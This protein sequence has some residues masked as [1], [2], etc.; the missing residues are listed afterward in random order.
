[1]VL[2]PDA[3]EVA[4]PC[5]K[6]ERRGAWPVVEEGL[7]LDWSAFYGAEVSINKSVQSAI[8][9]DSCLAYALVGGL[10]HASSL[11]QT[12]LYSAVT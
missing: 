3:V 10:N 6:R 2:T 8:N 4:R 5:R 7:D 12:A 9:V 11:A 1:M